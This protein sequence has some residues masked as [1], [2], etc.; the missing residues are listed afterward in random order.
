M[1]FNNKNLHYMFHQL[2]VKSIRLSC[3]VYTV[4][5]KEGKEQNSN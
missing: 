2:L 1:F 5:V 3:D 4:G